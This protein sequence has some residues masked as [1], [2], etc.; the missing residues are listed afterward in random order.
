MINKLGFFVFVVCIGCSL[1]GAQTPQVKKTTVAATSP[2]S[3]KDMY[4]QYCAACH[5]KEG[6]GDGPAAVALKTPPMDL[7]KL[8][9]NN[10]GKFPEVRVVRIIEGSDGVAA[11]GS[12]DMPV[13]GEIFHPM[14]ASPATAKVRL[15]KLST[16]R[17]SMQGK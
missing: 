14:D 15:A 2:A 16:Y 4:L 6:K 11:H 1:L 9:A 3:G 13:W 17:Q 7:P 12:R 8:S 5:G 10:D